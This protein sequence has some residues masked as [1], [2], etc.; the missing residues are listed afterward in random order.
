MI[1][2]Q[3]YSRSSARIGVMEVAPRCSQKAENGR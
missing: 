2:G 1:L 3:S